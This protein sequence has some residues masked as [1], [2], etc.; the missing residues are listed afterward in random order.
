MPTLRDIEQAL[1]LRD[2]ETLVAL[3]LDSSGGPPFVREGFK[4]ENELWEFKSNCP[5]IGREHENAWAHIAKDVLAFHNQKG[6]VIVFG[7]EDH[8]FR[9]SGATTRLDSKLFNDRTR[10]YVGD[11]IWVDYVRAHIQ[12]DQ[13]YVGLALIPSRG[14][15]LERFRSDAPG[16][17]G[18]KLFERGQSA[19]RE[20]DASRILSQLEANQL[21]QRLFAPRIGQLFAVDE[22]LFKILAPEYQEFTEREKPCAQIET[23]LANERAAVTSVV[24]IGGVGKTALAT[25]AVLR[26]YYR[27]DFD[28]IVS[29]TAKDRELTTGG[30]KAIDP[31]LTSFEALLDA[32]FDTMQL[33]DYKA[34]PITE[35]VREARGCLQLGRGLLYVDNLETV[36]DPRIIE[37]LDDLPIGTRAIVTSRRSRVRVSVVPI[38]LGPLEDNECSAFI[39]S[40]SKMTGLSYAAKLS[41]AERVQIGRACDGIPLAI[42]WTLARSKSPSQALTMAEAI[43]GS[44]R[45]GEQLLEFSFRRVF[46]TMAPDER[47]IVEVLSLFHRPMPI[48]AV[49]VGA[50]KPESSVIDNLEALFEDSVVQRFFDSEKNDYVYTLSPMVRAFVYDQ[51]TTQFDLER[52]IRLRLQDWFEA[53]DIKDPRD[54]IV[55]REIRQGKGASETGLL[56]LATGAE[57]RGDIQTAEEL[58]DQAL[59]RNP[60]SWKAARAAA[61]FYRHKL[62]NQATALQLYEKAAAYAPARGPDR[63]LIFREWGMLLRHS[64][65]PDATDQAIEKFEVALAETPNDVV[66]IDAL[67]RMHDRRGAY[68]RVIALL[69]PLETHPQEKTRAMAVPLLAKAYERVGEHLKLAELRQRN[70]ALLN[71]PR[72]FEQ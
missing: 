47:S 48:E 37:F 43:T 70:A 53:R 6:G 22:P 28:F 7:F 61:E 18:E 32:A 25:W 33:R 36:D 14:P 38:D 19:I 65:A 42:R 5:R 10:R 11:R 34:L 13:R 55:V 21:S 69:E 12:A 41:K 16:I 52:K 67:A 17:N 63:A 58:Y 30:I 29:I 31:Q 51:V 15:T 23:A 1:R 49:L 20:G 26:A 3:M 44:G 45:R 24:G 57:R 64:G 60:N 46:E 54:R 35:K 40:L 39:E 62:N 27:K 8:T 2:A 50:A 4:T 9:F 59:V 71:T 56:D 72:P 66:T 68:R